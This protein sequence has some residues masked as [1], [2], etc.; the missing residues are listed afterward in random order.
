MTSPKPHWS[1]VP[2]VSL[3]SSVKRA[4]FCMVN[5]AFKALQNGIK[6]STKKSWPWMLRPEDTGRNRS[7]GRYLIYFDFKSRTCMKTNLIL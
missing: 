3:E 5:R 4:D 2:P 7:F 1:H 6:I